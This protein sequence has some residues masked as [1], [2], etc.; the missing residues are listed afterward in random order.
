MTALGNYWNVTFFGQRKMKRSVRV[1]AAFWG[2]VAATIAAFNSVD[3]NAAALVAPTLVWV[4]VA[5]ALNYTV[6]KMNPGKG[7]KE[8]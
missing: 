1:M 8:D 4:T 6:V 2:S 7:A 3:K 5:A